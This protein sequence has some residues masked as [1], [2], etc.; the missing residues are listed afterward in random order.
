MSG[1]QATKVFFVSDWTTRG[2]GLG[3]HVNVKHSTKLFFF[4]F[5]LFFLSR[6]D[7]G[8]ELVLGC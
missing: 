6:P 4:S 1:S 2:R 5:F 3:S 8:E 7:D